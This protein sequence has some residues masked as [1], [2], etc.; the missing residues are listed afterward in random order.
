MNENEL[1][2]QTKRLA[3]AEEKFLTTVR[4][5]V[6]ASDAL[7]DYLRDN[8]DYFHNHLHAFD[9]TAELMASQIEM[10]KDI[11]AGMQA[12]VKGV[13]ANNLAIE[14]NTQQTKALLAKVDSYFGTTSGLDY[15]N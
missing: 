12:V 6:G 10:L 14:E 4:L 5:F 1:A 8:R 7:R 11:S 9:K 13:G 2:E 3:K 15:E